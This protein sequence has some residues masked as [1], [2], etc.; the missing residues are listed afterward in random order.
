MH[1]RF[2]QVP[3]PN[4]EEHILAMIARITSPIPGLPP[5]PR[6]M[7]LR[8]VARGVVF[9]QRMRYDIF[10]ANLGLFFLF[11]LWGGV[12]E[13]AKFGVRN[14]HRNRLSKLRSRT[15]GVEDSSEQN[16]YTR[17]PHRTFLA[18]I[19]TLYY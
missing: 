12:G 16:F 19:A 17:P 8:I 10:L 11:I 4:S 6:R 3:P 9:L 13:Q 1:G 2:V 7:T 5:K 15:Y 18:F 14:A